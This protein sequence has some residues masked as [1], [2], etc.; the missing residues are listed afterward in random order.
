MQASTL[1][2]HVRFAAR[3]LRG[4]P[5]QAAIVI[6]GL[7]VGLALALL[8]AAYL[9]DTVW[10]DTGLPSIDRLVAL[11]WRVRG[12]GGTQTDWYSDVPAVA[13]HQG[14]KD[15]GAPVDAISRLMQIDLAMQ[16][17]SGAGGQP[18]HAK[19]NTVLADGDIETLFAL[20]PVAGNLQVALSSPEGLVLTTTGAQKLFGTTQALGRSVTITVPTFEE[21]PG[22]SA[23]V[24]LTVMAVLP[25][26][27]HNGELGR[28]EAMAGFMSPRAKVFVKQE[29]GWWLG[30]GHLVARLRP[31][32][33][34]A[35]LGDLAQH[36]IDQQGL[37][38]GLPADFMKGGGKPA[39]LRCLPLRDLPLHGAGSDVRRLRLGGLLG[40]AIGVL[41][42]AMINFVN[43]WGL[44]TLR[45][46]REIG[47]R[48]SL[49][50][51]A[52]ALVVQMLVEALL[53]SLLA[54]AL[55]LL[56]AW[57]ATPALGAL[58][59]HG[60]DHSVLAPDMVAFALA[61]C[62]FVAALSAL[63]LASIAM[64]VRPAESLAGRSHSEGRAGRWLRRGLTVLQFGAASLFAALT[65]VM[66]W[67]NRFTGQ[68]DRGFL[69]ED[70]LA[71]DIAFDTPP[72]KTDALL[73]RIRQW[74]EVIA[75]AA[76]NDVPGRNFANWYADFGGPNGARTNLRTGLVFTP[77]LL[78]LYGV[79]II[80]GRLSAT[81]EAEVAANGAVL[82]RSAARA[83]GFATPEAAIGQTLQV[84]PVFHNGKPLTVV[85]V[86]D[87]V[88]LEGARNAH[89]PV[90][91]LPL[92]QLNGG[93]ASVH[94][95]D[96]VRTHQRLDALLAA[97]FPEEPPQVLTVREQYALQYQD[98]RHQ[99]TWIT[100]TCVI[101][102]LLAA[103]G[104]YALAAYTLRLRE[105]EIVLR[106]LH[107]AGPGAVA[108]L[109]AREFATVAGLGCLLGLPAAAWLAQLW[110]A[111]FLERA[112][113]GPF[114]LWPLLASVLALSVVTLL[115]VLKH[116][117]A[118]FALR[119]L[120]ALQG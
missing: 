37:P 103:V 119:P 87:D 25:E 69:T 83:L 32:A 106:K 58:L 104:I 8:S 45:R 20:R 46:Q 54:G 16:S 66:G 17:S 96:P 65:I 105:R 26:S 52:G 40:A 99:A 51:D 118:A 43:L 98:D 57:W 81:H 86:V 2:L 74:P 113:M 85:A 77:G 59:W 30:A 63:P 10:A 120:Q 23:Q 27:R 89:V 31:G 72:A 6:L 84:S 82:D 117:R 5:G 41:A 22:S 111:R 91:M 33:T 102:L 114:T 15:A 78:D 70:R 61:C 35:M 44:R 53:V 93:T 28:F 11:E 50:A 107:G 101:A 109:L 110:L 116:L 49:G 76:S 94:S 60:F 115:A 13:L 18:R 80:A 75:A 56:F 55:G 97:E 9:R 38:P 64:R 14:L 12:P 29:S 62:V 71:F 88:H 24:S 48:K 42:L 95:R 108:R 68:L 47:L 92:K 39:Y 7:A 67:Q 21:V 34:P 1:L 3:Q 112:P 4:A 90:L 36:L 79:P 100:A 73:A 19:L